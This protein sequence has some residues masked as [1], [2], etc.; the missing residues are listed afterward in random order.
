MIDGNLYM[1]FK[2]RPWE[3]KDLE[4][5]CKHA[6]NSNIT[7]FMSDGFPDS[8]NKWESFIDYASNDEANLY[9]AIEINGEA[10]GGIGVSPQKD[11]MRKNAEIG[12]WLSENYWD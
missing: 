5:V 9:L 12:Y 7:R 8:K 2:L 6:N 4:S 10:V 1:N 3:I 11:Y